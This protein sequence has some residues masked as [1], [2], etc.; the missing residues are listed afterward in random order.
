MKLA[1][2]IRSHTD[3][4]VQISDEELAC[5]S[6]ILDA[7]S[8]DV[9]FCLRWPGVV[10]L[11]SMVSLASGDVGSLAVNAL[12]SDVLDVAQETLAILSQT[13]ELQLDQPIAQ[14]NISDEKFDRIIVSRLHNLLQMSISG[15]SPL[16]AEVRKRYL[17]VCLKCMWYFGRAYNQ[18]R[19]S[20]PLP[21]YFPRTLASPEI[22]RL[23]QTE[24][25][26]V[27]RAMGRC[28][29]ALVV[30]NLTADV[31]SRTDSNVQM[32]DEE[33]ACLSAILDAESRDVVFFLR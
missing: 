17:R 32:G 3:S 25:D 6:A 15:T 26:P 5:L 4:N 18:P 27:S 13:A 31:R 24:Q 16:T 10:E 21:S 1:A 33:L 28:F 9:M 14:L 12:P 23:I 2:G 7:E 20:Q 29:C 22:I 30:M 19:A 11:A 8:R